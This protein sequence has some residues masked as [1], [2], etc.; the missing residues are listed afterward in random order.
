MLSPIANHFL[1]VS[2]YGNSQKQLI[3]KVLLQFY[4]QN[5]HN[6]M[7]SPTEEGGLEEARDED[8]NIII[9]DSTLLNILPPQLK[10]MTSQ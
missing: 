3:P 8:N 2:I 6:R 7:V 1:C 9:S 4:V 5:Y 10:N